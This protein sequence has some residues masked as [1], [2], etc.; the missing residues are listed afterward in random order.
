MRQG[1][2]CVLFTVCCL[3]F[4]PLNPVG[5]FNWGLLFTPLNPVGQFNWALLSAAYCMLLAAC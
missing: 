5:L 1:S 2:E 4:T 3:L